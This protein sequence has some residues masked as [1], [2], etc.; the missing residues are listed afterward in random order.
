MKLRILRRAF[1]PALLIAASAW[2]MPLPESGTGLPRDVSLNGWRIDFLLKTASVGVV[3]LFLIM[4]GILAFAMLRHRAPHK[5]HYDHGDGRKNA[6]MAMAISGTIFFG[7]DGWLYVNAMQDLSQGFWK[8]PAADAP[9][10]LLV[11]VNAQQWA[12]NFR[13]AGPDG[14]WNTRDDIVTLNDLRVPVDTPVIFQITSK[15]VIHSLYFPNLRVKQ[16]AIPG[17]VTR[18][19]VQA[20]KAGQFDIACA[21]HCGTHHYKM[22]GMLTVLPKDEYARWAKETSANSARAFDETRVQDQ[23]GWQWEKM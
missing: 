1:V 22:K 2:A 8:Y 3:L 19:W 20:K 13:Y 17:N 6:L 15:D 11:E 10:T 23:W 18:L 14:K 9:G 5:A 4:V 7:L 12:W 16:D 21:Q